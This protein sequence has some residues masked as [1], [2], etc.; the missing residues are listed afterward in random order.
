MRNAIIILVIF[1][2][3]IGLTQ[4]TG[5]LQPIDFKAKYEQCSHE[6][7]DITVLD[8]VFEHLLN[9]EAIVNIIEGEH[10]YD[11]GDY[12]HA[13]FETIKNVQETIA[14]VPSFIFFELSELCFCE[15]TIKYPYPTSD[16][17]SSFYTDILRPPIC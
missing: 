3:G 5:I 7:H 13:P 1:L 6:D 15:T 12:P 8:F 2:L 17:L 14:T 16:Y 11:F 9:L 10:E 4:P